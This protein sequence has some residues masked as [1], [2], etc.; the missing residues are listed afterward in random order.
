MRRLH[1]GRGDDPALNL[2]G[3]FACGLDAAGVVLF[4][5]PSRAVCSLWAGVLSAVTCK[6]SSDGTSRV[7]RG[8]SVQAV[9][10]GD[11]VFAG[12]TYPAALVVTVSTRRERSDVSAVREAL[13]HF[14]ARAILAWMYDWRE[15][16]PITCCP[17][18]GWRWRAHLPLPQSASSP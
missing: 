10:L 4:A 15:A 18:H 3:A 7:A 16:K 14:C 5:T 6:P 12:C 11:E 1:G 8:L 2:T 9:E 17:Q 13:R